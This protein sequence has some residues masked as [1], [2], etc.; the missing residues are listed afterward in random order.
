MPQVFKPLMYVFMAL[1]LAACATQ[2]ASEPPKPQ[3]V[4]LTSL[5]AGASAA[6]Q[7]ESAFTRAIFDAVNAWRNEKGVAP[8]APDAA[9]Q[10]AAAIHSADMSLRN[11]VGSF[12]PDGQGTRERVLAV[13]PNRNGN[14][15]ETISLMRDAAGQP[16]EAVATAVVKGWTTDPSRRKVLKDATLTRSGVGVASKG[17]D[18]YVTEVF[19]TQ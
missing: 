16:A 1:A 11:F 13:D 15:F 7:G 2:N 5:P 18:L 8:L 9:L 17:A 4:S 6:A 3:R 12:N 14:V 19:A 10:R